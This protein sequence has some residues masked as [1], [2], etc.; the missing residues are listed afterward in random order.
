M[1]IEERNDVDIDIDVDEP[2]LDAG[3]GPPPGHVDGP[4]GVEGD[5][6]S[7][8][9]A[10]SW[11]E[12]DVADVTDVGDGTVDVIVSTSF[13]NGSGCVAF[14]HATTGQFK[15]EIWS[16]ME[17]PRTDDTSDDNT[18]RILTS[19]GNESYWNYFWTFGGTSGTKTFTLA[20]TNR[21]NLIA[22]SRWVFERYS[23]GLVNKVTE[24]KDIACPTEADNSCN[25]GY[26]A[27]L[28]LARVYIN[29]IHN[30]RKFL[31]GHE[32]GH[33]FLAHWFEYNPQPQQNVGQGSLYSRNEGGA[34]CEWIGA[35]DHAMHSKEYSSAA[36][37]D[38]F[39]HYD[40]TYA[41]NSEAD[42]AGAFW[43]YK[44]GTGV[45][46]VD[47]EVGPEGGETRYLE[48]ICIGS[49][50]GRGVELDWARQLW[51]FR[52]NSGTKPSNYA[53]TRQMKNGLTSGGWHRVGTWRM[54]G[55]SCWMGWTSTTT[56]MGPR[57]TR[58]G[59]TS[60]RSMA[61]TTR[62]RPTTKRH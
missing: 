38:G 13:A 46:E 2:R 19:A 15:L 23:D 52:T 21:T 45:T 42:W 17:V 51:D 29:P 49:D 6:V 22:V 50:V 54:A 36:F 24:I 61:S 60:V 57:S 4:A 11:V 33:A 16:E 58:A 47:M 8:P 53:P 28:S 40:A 32:I 12:L 41:F 48:E 1:P 14:T 34:D 35:G 5:P 59:T 20:Q 62:T 31:I 39:P 26:T 56:T 10:L 9:V 55:R 7:L 25:G 43:Y 44:D 30:K 3:S 27:N 18:V 37:V